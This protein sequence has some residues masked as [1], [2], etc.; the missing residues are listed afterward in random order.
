MSPV[1]EYSAL[2]DLL[3][4]ALQKGLLVSADVIITVADIPLIGLNLRLAVANIETMLDY[5]MMTD[6]SEMHKAVECLE[7]S[8]TRSG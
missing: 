5:G 6:W 4:R 2:V 1:R 3:D 7:E 8:T